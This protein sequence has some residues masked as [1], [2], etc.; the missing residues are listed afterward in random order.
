MYFYEVKQY[1]LLFY[2]QNLERTFSLELPDLILKR[3]ELKTFIDNKLYE[4]EIKKLD[5]KINKLQAN[6]NSLFGIQSSER[7]ET[8][9]KLQDSVIS[10]FDGII[11]ATISA[12]SLILIFS[13]PAL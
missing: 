3:D 5:I 7:R 8:A 12:I 11:V 4:E 9:K 6:L 10:I 1:W 13:K 2:L